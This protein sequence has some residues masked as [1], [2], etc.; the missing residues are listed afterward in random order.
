MYKCLDFV[1]CALA[2]AQIQQLESKMS[3]LKAPAGSDHLQGLII[4]EEEMKDEYGCGHKDGELVAM[5]KF[6]SLQDEHQ[7]V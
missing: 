7:S 1:G 2:D 6:L 3:S 4:L 5:G